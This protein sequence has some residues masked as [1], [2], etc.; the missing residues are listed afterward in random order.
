MWQRNDEYAERI[1][2][3]ALEAGEQIICESPA[4]RYTWSNSFRGKLFLTN[5]RLVF[6]PDEIFRPKEELTVARADI[7]CMNRRSF[8]DL[9]NV[10]I[11]IITASNKKEKF[12]VQDRKEWVKALDTQNVLA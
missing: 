4:S 3:P 12:A 2:P 8:F 7:T 5:R 9:L 11:I 1:S 10:K 6:L